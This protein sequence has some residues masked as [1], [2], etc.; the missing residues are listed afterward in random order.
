VY[1]IFNF[2]DVIGKPIG[3]ER[4]IKWWGFFLLHVL[5]TVL[6]GTLYPIPLN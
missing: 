3:N 5:S 4:K 2:I 6:F 1:C